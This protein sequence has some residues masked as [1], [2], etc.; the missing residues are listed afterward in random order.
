MYRIRLICILFA[1]V[2][3]FSCSALADKKIEMSGGPK[4]GGFDRLASRIVDLLDEANPDSDAY[5]LS[6]RGSLDNIRKVG[7]Q[8]ADYGLCFE[9]DLYLAAN[10]LLVGDTTRYLTLRTMA[11]LHR[12]TAH[13]VSLKNLGI[14]HIDELKGKKIGVGMPGSGSANA[15]GRFFRLIGLWEMVD[16]QYLPQDEAVEALKNSVVAAI[17][18]LTEYPNPILVDL[19]DDTDIVLIDIYPL[20]KKHGISEIM[21]FYRATDIPKNTY[22]GVE[23]DVAT[24]SDAAFWI[25]AETVKSDAAYNALKVVFSA[26]GLEEIADSGMVVTQ[27]INKRI[28]PGRINPLHE[29]SVRFWMEQGVEL[30]VS[31]I[32]VGQ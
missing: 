20:G 3:A 25:A 19:A 29:G 5:K 18:M 4:G 11:V 14:S 27:S 2:L 32:K 16:K 12:R 30:P 8:H 23:R 7:H 10:G 26:E 17:W 22:K 9:S 13:L 1:G 15:A 24:F 6:S 21:P 31:Q 28:L